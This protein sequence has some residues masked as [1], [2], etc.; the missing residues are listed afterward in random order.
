MKFAMIGS[1]GHARVPLDSLSKQ[2][3]TQ[4]VAVAR[5]GQDDPLDYVGKHLA[6]PAS[7]PIYDDYRKMLDEVQPDAV[8]VFMPLYRLAEASAEAASRGCHVFTEK[9]LATSLDDLENLQSAVG[10][11]HVRIA[12]CMTMRMAPAFQ[13]IRQAVSDGR[14]GEPILASGQK[15]YPFASRDAYYKQ[16]ETY[17]GSILWQAIHALDFV[18]WATGRDYARVAAM[19]SNA[20]HPSHPGMEDNGGLLL[21]FSGGG[22]AVI[23]YDYLRPWGKVQRPWGDDRLRIA[24]AKGIV[25]T[26]D[27]GS[28]AVLLAPDYEEQLHLPPERDL[29][30]E[31]V[32]AIQGRGDGLISNDESF[33][34]TEV[35]LKARDAADEGRVVEL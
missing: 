11:N 6:A 4:L 2:P 19:E 18:Y 30:G 9:P 7:L 3:D 27:H 8:G 16:R 32:D 5:W 28:R 13:A 21:E 17:G 29:F 20:A 24:G 26:R 14:I 22:H 12:A 25:E 33:R 35:G 23:R 34:I 1:Y 15:S 10:A 31:F